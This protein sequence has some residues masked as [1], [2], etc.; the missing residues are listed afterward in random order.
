LL[1]LAGLFLL[2]FS[3]VLTFSPTVRA[4]ALDVPYRWD[5]WLGYAVW[6]VLFASA[7]IYTTRRMPD[8]DPYFL[9]LAGLLSGWGLLTIWRLFPEFGQRQALWLV[10]GLALMISFLHFSQDLN[11]LRR[12]KYI[13]LTL[14]LIL[15]AF[16]LVTGTGPTGTVYAP[17]WLVGEGSY[18]QPSEPLKLLLIIY[19]SAYFATSRGRNGAPVFTLSKN[20]LPLLAPTLIMTGLALLLLVFQRD[21][22]TAT[23]FLFIYAVLVYLASGRKII[24]LVT[25]A[26]LLFSGIFGYALFDVVRIRV[27]AWI[28][29]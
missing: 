18:L 3:L 10:L 8:R 14:G 9:P 20:L 28:N 17:R 7:H 15:T 19:L 5:H 29:P 25:A 23:I 2:L 11:F 24:L 6:A 27:D 16:T 22:G 13:W 21:L 4:R 26:I 12:Y 1:F